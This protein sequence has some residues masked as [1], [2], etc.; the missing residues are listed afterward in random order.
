[1]DKV[2]SF[3]LT[4]GARIGNYCILETI[5]RGCEGEVFKV[6]EVP[7]G[8]IRALKLYR[9]I[10]LESVRHL[11]H[12]AWFYEQVRPCGHFP[13]YYHYGQWF[14]GRDQGC[15]Y[16]IFEFVKGTPLDKQIKGLTR[17][18]KV[19]LFFE[20]LNAVADVHK[21]GFAVGDFA[22]LNNV[23]LT[24]QEQIVFT[25]CEPGSPGRPNRNFEADCTTE[26]PEAA[27]VTFGKAIPPPVKTLLK[28]ITSIE[29]FGKTTL[30]SILR[31]VNG[32]IQALDWHISTK[33]HLSKKKNTGKG[34]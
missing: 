11:I 14:F 7:T 32:S 12:F 6:T 4:R 29:L 2:R 24:P 5:G 18:Q 17:K 30:K 20:L 26:L 19:E 22:N 13:I 31:K 10:E 34:R 23:I 27:K 28:E 9:T 21:C 33:R 25:D 16:L 1:M 3:N 15:W 8:A